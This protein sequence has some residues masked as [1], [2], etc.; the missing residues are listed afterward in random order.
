[1]QLDI[2]AHRKKLTVD[3]KSIKLVKLK[4]ETQ[5]KIDRLKKKEAKIP[6]KEVELKYKMK[7]KRRVLNL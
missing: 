3:E 5:K 6:K 7:V 2:L 1:M 4:N